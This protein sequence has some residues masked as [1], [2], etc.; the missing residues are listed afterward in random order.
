MR[1]AKYFDKDLYSKW[2]R[3]HDGIAMCDVDSVEIC[4][5]K[6]CWKPLAIIE[7]LYDL[8]QTKKKY[9]TIVEHI[10]RA[11]KVPV[12]LV[13]YK[14]S[15]GD[16]LSFQVAQK[17]PIKTPLTPHCQAE[18]VD[19]LRSIQLKHQKVCKYGK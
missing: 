3:L 7:H 15:T 6:G 19:I 12:F 13:Y 11:L 1:H 4:M 14:K 18:W 8:N 16:T 9:T 5:N 2:H 10:G 17:H